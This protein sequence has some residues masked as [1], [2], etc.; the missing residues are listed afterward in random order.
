[1]NVDIEYSERLHF[2]LTGRTW[3]LIRQHFPELLPKVSL[4]GTVWGP[5]KQ[6]ITWRDVP[7]TANE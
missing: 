1:M 4:L 7:Q 3:R 6:L 2:A 5:G